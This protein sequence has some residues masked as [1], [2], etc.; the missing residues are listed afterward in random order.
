M[1]TARKAASGLTDGAKAGDAFPGNSTG[2]IE[3][4][5]HGR[6]TFPAAGAG[7]PVA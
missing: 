2:T 6:S 3:A 5:G 1:S 4:A 7:A